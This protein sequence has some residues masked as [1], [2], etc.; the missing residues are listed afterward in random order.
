L[1]PLTIPNYCFKILVFYG[2]QVSLPDIE[3]VRPHEFEALF[4]C[5][6]YSLLSS[7]SHRVY[8]EYFYVAAAKTY[9]P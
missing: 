8:F 2:V 5:Q 7:A 6:Q 1:K 4:S 3:L 9:L